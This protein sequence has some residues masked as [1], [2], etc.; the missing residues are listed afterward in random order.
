MATSDYAWIRDIEVPGAAP[1]SEE[2]KNRSALRTRLKALLGNNAPE[3]KAER[4]K[5]KAQLDAE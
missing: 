4:A 2:T 5:I 1:V 3:A